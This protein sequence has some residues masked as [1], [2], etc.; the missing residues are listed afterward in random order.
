MGVHL[1]FR[2][3]PPVPTTRLLP[4]GP[5]TLDESYALCKDFNKRHGTTYY[6]STKLLPQIK[7]HHVHAL[8]AFARYA[9]DIVDEIP[10]Q[11]GRAVPT[12]ARA[13]ALATFGDRF[14]VDLDAGGSDDPVLKAVVH[15]VRAFDIDPGTFRRFLRSMTMDLTVESYRSWDELLV[16]MDGS[17][18]VIGEMMLPI[19]EPTDLAAALPHARD[20]GN[21][22]QL[23]NFLRDIDEDLDRGR[24]YI[25]LEDSVRFDVDLTQRKVSPEFVEMMRFEIERCRELYRSAEI[26]ISMMPPR[27][28]KCVRAAH[29]LYSRILDE[30]EHQDYDVFESRASVS[31][32]AKA[33][34][35]TSLLR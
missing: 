4:T 17:A 27:S 29:T 35:V 10:S 16:Y 19:L 14:F 18:A 28:A 24:Q 13:E 32:F 3:R 25:P 21:A 34:L 23:T 22:F 7:R 5:V 12:A 8:Y 30:I 20:L 26:G 33:R 1:P 9:D 15:T 11:G 2:R 31:T 6:W